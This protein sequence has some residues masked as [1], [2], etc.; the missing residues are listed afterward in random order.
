MNHLTVVQYLAYLGGGLSKE[1]RAGVENHLQNCPSCSKA[2][3][4]LHYLGW[5]IRFHPVGEGQSEEVPSLPDVFVG[6]PVIA[7]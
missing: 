6:P 2:T 5:R 1:E 4:S 7:G 3:H